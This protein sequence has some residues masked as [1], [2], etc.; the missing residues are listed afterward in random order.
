MNLRIRLWGAIG[1][2]AVIGLVAW[3][4]PLSFLTSAV[5]AAETKSTDNQTIAQSVASAIAQ[6]VP[7]HGYAVSVECHR[8]VVTVRG[9]VSDPGQ[10]ARVVG[11]AQA[12]PAV[13]KVVNELIVGE[14]NPAQPVSYIRSAAPQQPPEGGPPGEVAPQQLAPA[15]PQHVFKGTGATQYDYPYMPPYSWP[16]YAPYPNYSAVQYPKCYPNSAWPNIGPFTPYPEPPLDW[17]EVK[18]KWNDGHWY[19]RFKGP[20]ESLSCFQCPIGFGK[21]DCGWEVRF[22]KPM[23]TSRYPN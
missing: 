9:T 18:L 13:S 5:A 3:T 16:A 4:D 20:C 10:M 12:S 1:S 8:G 6:A 22:K 15:T 23:H 7:E 17:R 14:A 19:L 2:F 11:A 21:S